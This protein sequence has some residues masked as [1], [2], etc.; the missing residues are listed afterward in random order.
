MSLKKVF[1]NSFYYGIIPKISTLI[2]VLLLP[3]LTPYLTP[4]D[5]GIWGIVSSYS[6]IFLALAPLGLHVH[7][8]NSY[9]EYGK[10]WNIVWGRILYFF[11]I[12]GLF[13][14]LLYIG[15]IWLELSSLSCIKRILIAVCS[16]VPI[17][18]FG[19]ATLASHLFPLKEMPK[20]LVFRN[21]IASLMAILT[22]FVVV[23]IFRLGY[24]GFIMS[25][26]VGSLATFFLFLSPLYNKEQIRP[27]IES[28]LKRIRIW[29]RIA[30]PVIPHALGFL[31]LS[32]SSRIVMAWYGVAI[33]DIGLFS[34]GY[35]MGDYVTIVTTSLV[36]A[37]VPQMQKAYRNGDFVIYRKLYYLCQ[38]TTLCSVFGASLWMPEIYSFL[39]RNDAFQ[40][41]S[42]I[43]SY[44]C[45]ANVLLPFYSFSSTVIFIEKRTKQLLWL[46]F[47]PGISNIILCLLFIP[48]F[49]Y[50]VAIYSTLFAYWSQILIPFISSYHQKMVQRWLGSRKKLILLL[51]LLVAMLGIV[52]N[53]VEYNIG[54]KL[55]VSLILII[56]YFGILRIK[57]IDV[58]I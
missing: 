19:N 40:E 45:F 34:N 52:I 31:L 16:A 55:V 29:L 6:G 41:S 22:F 14:S 49:G 43:A 26:M 47:L 33:T 2:N 3:F 10:Y 35:M 21:L 44:I 53:V 17:L 50:K 54:V 12:A 46:V 25:S 4:Y 38:L 18:L 27:I 7:L 11:F 36:T 24:W 8:T 39:I 58:A 23:Y 51:I 1:V 56:S 42:S 32:S 57:K 28:N 5:Y 9:F 30:L 20:P 48:Y 37:L 15:V 13:F